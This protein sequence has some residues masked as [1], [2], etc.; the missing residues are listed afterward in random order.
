V[1]YVADQ[2][3]SKLIECLTNLIALPG[4]TVEHRDE[5]EEALGHSRNGID[6]AD[7]LH[8]AVSRSCSEAYD[9]R[10]PRLCTPGKKATPETAMQSR[11]CR[12]SQ[13]HFGAWDGSP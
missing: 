4:V 8:F 10:R 3:G 5:I 11:P 7:A 6:F 9:V 1:Q 2:P 13:Q 12:E